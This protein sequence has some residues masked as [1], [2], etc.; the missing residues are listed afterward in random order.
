M[1]GRGSGTF[2][3]GA[4][5]FARIGAASGLAAGE[6]IESLRTLADRGVLARIGAAVRPNTIGASTLAALSAPAD[7]LDDAAAMVSLEPGVN[8]NYE[9]EHAFNLWFVVSA[10]DRQ[11]VLATLQRIEAR[12][13]CRVIDLPLERA[14]HIDLGF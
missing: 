10:P 4:E 9:R 2:R 11:S 6:V 13:G 8:H 5:P 14:Y 12:T 7:A 1:P 3:C